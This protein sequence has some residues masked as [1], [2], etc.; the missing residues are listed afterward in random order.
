VYWGGLFLDDFPD[1]FM[2]LLSVR[3]RGT[4]AQQA[5][6]PLPSLIHNGVPGYSPAEVS[7]EEP[8]EGIG[9]IHRLSARSAVSAMVVQS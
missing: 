2:A 4:G 9:R 5:G 8:E 6:S 1:F 7:K 3:F